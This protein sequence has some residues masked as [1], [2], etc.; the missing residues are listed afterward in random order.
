MRDCKR[1]VVC[2][3]QLRGPDGDPRDRWDTRVRA[4]RRRRRPAPTRSART[5]ARSAASAPSGS[6]R[7][8][9]WTIITLAPDA[10]VHCGPRWQGRR[11]HPRHGNVPAG[12]HRRLLDGDDPWVWRPW[13]RT[14]RSGSTRSPGL[15]GRAG[16]CFTTGIDPG[17]ANDLFPMTLMGCAP[18]APGAGARILDYLNYEGDYEDGRWGSAGHAR[19]R[20]MPS[21]PTS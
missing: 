11:Q 9:T 5:P 8:T 21:T 12:G 20:P 13:P 3:H 19:V 7:R 4:R 2:G 14:R 6:P 18:G 15:P 16:S 17:F 10:L 1:V